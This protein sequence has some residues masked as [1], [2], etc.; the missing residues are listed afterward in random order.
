ME[1]LHLSEYCATNPSQSERNKIGQALWDFYNFQLHQLREVHADP[2]P[3]NFLVNEHNELIAIDFGCIKQ[4]PEEFYTPYFELVQLENLNHTTTYL[5][6]LRQLEIIREDDSEK[7]I[8]IIADFFYELLFLFTE[9]LRSTSFD[10]SN[11]I[12]F[13]KIAALGESITKDEQIKKLNGNRGSRH[14]LYINRTFFGLY[15]LLHDLR[16]EIKTN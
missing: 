9:P 8:K 11:D 13:S 3:G 16:A 7:E 5:S 10:F 6:K 4:I 15:N 12:Y 1:G 14:F 2:H